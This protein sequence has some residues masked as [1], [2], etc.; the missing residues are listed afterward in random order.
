MTDGERKL[1]R[2]L[3]CE[4]TQV[5]ALVLFYIRAHPDHGT[6]I[7][8]AFNEALDDVRNDLA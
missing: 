3:R 8:K 1:V 4:S 6:E 2:G 5:K 7:V